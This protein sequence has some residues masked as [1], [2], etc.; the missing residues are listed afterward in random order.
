[1]AERARSV[2]ANQVPPCYYGVHTVFNWTVNTNVVLI[3]NN[4]RS[5][6]TASHCRVVML[7]QKSP[8]LSAELWWACLLYTGCS[9]QYIPAYIII[10]NYCFEFLERL[11]TFQRYTS[12][13]LS[14]RAGAIPLVVVDG[15]VCVGGTN[16]SFS[17]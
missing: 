6:C 3:Y 2:I 17:S 5:Y 15:Q 12:A 4:R 16:K 1:M 8:A 14:R 7:Q 11:C 10:L 13:M 9:S